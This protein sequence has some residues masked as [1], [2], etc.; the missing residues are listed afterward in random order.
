MFISKVSGIGRANTPSKTN[1][2]NN[3]LN[4]SFASRTAQE[5][6]KRMA[7][8]LDVASFTTSELPDLLS[9]KK[10]HPG[11]S[12]VTMVKPDDRKHR[13]FFFVNGHLTQ[14]NKGGL[15]NKPQISHLFDPESGRLISHQ[16][17]A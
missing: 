5:I 15:L 1:H 11:K 16:T 7:G 8:K 12:I 3:A 14:I 6:S 2:Q 4:Q 13:I 10:T 9:L 17:N